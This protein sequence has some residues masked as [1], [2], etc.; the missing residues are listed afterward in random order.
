MTGS[1]A[2]LSTRRSGILTDP[3]QQIIWLWHGPCCCDIVSG[4]MATNSFLGSHYCKKLK[5]KC[6]IDCS[7]LSSEDLIFGNPLSDTKAL[8]MVR[9]WRNELLVTGGG[10]AGALLWPA[11]I[12][13]LIVSVVIFSCAEGMKGKGSAAESHAAT[14]GGGC[15]AACGAGCGG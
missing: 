2:V 7:D 8:E 11:L 12:A 6:I 10:S 1:N 15:G 5:Y 9:E 3:P 13:V 14:C 4:N